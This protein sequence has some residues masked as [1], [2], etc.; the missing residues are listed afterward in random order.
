MMR[1]GGQR[2]TVAFL[3]WL[4]T[5]A[6][7]LSFLPALADRRF[8]VLGALA[9]ALV[10]GTGVLLRLARTPPLLVLAAQLVVVAEALA[11][12]FGRSLKYG[13]LPTGKTLNGI[14]DLVQTG[15]SIS[16]RYAAPAPRSG[17]LLLMVVFAIACVAASVDA[18]ALGIG[19]V[20]LAGLPLLALYTVPVAALPKGIPFLLFVPGAACYIA[21][22]T[23]DERDRLSHWGRLVTRAPT[24]SGRSVD[25]SGLRDSG[26]RIGLAALSLAVVVPAVL[27]ALSVSLLDRNRNGGI[28]GDAVAGGPSVTFQ[29][30]MVTMAHSLQL[31]DPVNLLDVASEDV[32]PRYLRLAVLD[33]PGPQ[34]WTERRPASSDTVD[35]NNVLPSPPGVGPGVQAVPHTMVVSLTGNFPADSSWLPVPFDAH[36]V[37]AKGSFGYV[38]SDDTVLVRDTSDLQAMPPYQVSYS[39]LVP[40]VSQLQSSGPA[41]AEVRKRYGEVPTGVPDLVVSTARQVTASG[42]TPYEKALLLQGFFRDT[43]SFTYD[44]SASYGYGYDAMSSFLMQRRGFCQ[45]FAATMAMMARTVGIPSRV[46]VGF[47][48]SSSTDTDGHYVFTSHDVHAWPELYFDGVGWVRF[49]PTPRSHA[50]FPAY[51]PRTTAPDPKTAQPDLTSQ[52][53]PQVSRSIL[54]RGG[55]AATGGG[56]SGPGPGGSLP[57]TPWL[58]AFGLVVLVCVPGLSRWGLR[59]SRMARPLDDAEAAEAAWRELRDSMIDLHLPWTGSMT[60]RARERWVAS[61]L[62]GD[63][64]ALQALQRLARSVERARYA[65]R[66]VADAAAGA[67]ARTVVAA[68]SRAAGRGGRLRARMLPLSLLADLRA[69]WEEFAIRLQTRG[70]SIS[71][72]RGDAASGL[73][74]DS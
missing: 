22:L 65:D 37:D 14:S 47:L 68:L 19:R 4:A 33:Q 60:P 45:H 18:L 20:P 27:P 21:L 54:G 41:P 62:Q 6:M 35:L 26:R 43:G 38:P 30:P 7:S 53:A 24:D 55:S 71:S 50:V 10:V 40:S 12:G 16:Q 3:G 9:A 59:R 36:V 23:A 1:V 49:E 46:V 69:R 32:E 48:S 28:G 74:S 56:S 51:A 31:R 70:G 11:L 15:I 17:G 13:V 67:D 61:H 34:A 57:K 5:V 52:V 73:P 25:L 72:R 63:A 64:D 39:D 66:P 44:T 2:F 42:R 29:D 58:I 8:V